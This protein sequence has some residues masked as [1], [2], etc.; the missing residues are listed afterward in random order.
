MQVQANWENQ[1]LDLAGHIPHPQTRPFF[2]YWA[3][4]ASLRTAYKQAESVTA[5]HSKSF[6]F[7]SESPARGETFRRSCPLCL[8]PNR[9]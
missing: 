8:L 6:Y 2:S 5:E 7:A 1:L 9:G 3:G 4:D